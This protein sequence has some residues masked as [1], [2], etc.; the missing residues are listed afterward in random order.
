MVYYC[1]FV[2]FSVIVQRIL[3]ESATI[4]IYRGL[5]F[6]LGFTEAYSPCNEALKT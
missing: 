1:C 2:L 6:P 3:Y 4:F 5:N